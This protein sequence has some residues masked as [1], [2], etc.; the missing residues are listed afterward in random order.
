M[1][2][3]GKEPSAADTVKCAGPAP[4]PRAMTRLSWAAA[5]QV[6][7]DFS[8]AWISPPGGVS[9]MRER[10]KRGRRH[11]TS[12]DVADAESALSEDSVED[13]TS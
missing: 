6:L 4:L 11:T 9:M 12:V 2:E 10:E 8:R 5:V 3:G 1:Q 7:R 13:T